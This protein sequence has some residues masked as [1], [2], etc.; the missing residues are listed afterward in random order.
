MKKKIFFG[1]FLTSLIISAGASLLTSAVI[2]LDIA[3]N[4]QDIAVDILDSIFLIIIAIVDRK[5]TR[6]NSSH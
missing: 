2:F 4:W 6:L 3:E 5:S 1:I